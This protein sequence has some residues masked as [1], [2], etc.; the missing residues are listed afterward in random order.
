MSRHR[1]NDYYDEDIPR[2]RYY[3]C[4][5]GFC[6]A[7]DCKRCRPSTYKFAQ[8]SDEETTAAVDNEDES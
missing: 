8:N 5:D 4:S 1:D 6:G 7:E 2:T 3:S